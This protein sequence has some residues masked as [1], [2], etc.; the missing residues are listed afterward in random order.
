[1][2]SFSK[3]FTSS[4]IWELLHFQYRITIVSFKLWAR[5]FV[6]NFKGSLS[7]RWRHNGDDSVSNHQPHDCLLNR[8]TGADQ[9]K[10]QS[11]A[12]LAFVWGIHLGLVN[13]PHKWPVTRKMFSFDDV[14]MWNPTQ[15]M[16]P[17]HWK[18]CSLL[19]SEN[20]RAPR[21]TSSCF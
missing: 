21:F 3:P 16:M 2:G 12:S 5:Y 17:I 14:I 13:S 19:R 18:M 9:S 6:W 11:S 10:H 15:N 7:L 1:M 20:L 8:Y 4:W